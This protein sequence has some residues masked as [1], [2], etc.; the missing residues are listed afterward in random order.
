MKIGYPCINT[1]IT[2]KANN[3]FRLK[4]YTAEKFISTV[5]HNLEG[6]LKI[7]EYNVSKDLLFF[8][9]SSDIIPFA[10]HEI[11]NVDWQ[12][13]FKNQLNIIGDF[14]KLNN[15][16]ISMHPGQFVIINSSNEKIVKNS[17]KELI[18][19][20]QFL[21]SLNLDYTHKI[22][23]HVGGAYGDKITS[24]NRFIDNYKKLDDRIKNRLVI[25]NDERLYSV[26]DCLKISKSVNLPIIFDTLHH[27]CNNNGETIKEG[28]NLAINTWTGLDGVAMVD[29]SSQAQNCKIGKHCQTIDESHF[30][31]FLEDVR[32]F[33]FDIMV[34]VKDKQVSAL[35]VLKIIKEVKS[36]ND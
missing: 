19:H 6:L 32:D 13:L 36:T 16:R 7:L 22:Q 11:L 10:S 20:A 18:Y 35:K 3:T 30:R 8:R 4:S 5:K 33:N 2:A 34:E 25:E 17:E 27:E 28:L 26:Q 23:I 9:I 29:Y 14:I 21:N 1:E 31:K 24:Q 12:T 15:M